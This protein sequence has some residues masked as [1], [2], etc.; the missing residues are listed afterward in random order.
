LPILGA[1]LAAVLPRA[2]PQAEGVPVVQL[3]PVGA[4]VDIPGIRV[5]IGQPAART[6]IAS[7]VVLVKPQSRKFEQVHIA[8]LESV[9]EQRRCAHFLWRNRLGIFHLARGHAQNLEL[10]FIGWQSQR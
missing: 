3:H 5:T 9:F 4:G 7:A 8:S 6:K 2:H 10:R 1:N